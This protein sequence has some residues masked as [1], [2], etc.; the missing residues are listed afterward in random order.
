MLRGEERVVRR[1]RCLTT[2]V[3]L[4]WLDQP[5]LCEPTRLIFEIHEAWQL[6]T[7]MRG[8]QTAYHID[9]PV[10]GVN[11]MPVGAAALA[12]PFR[13][14]AIFSAAAREDEPLRV[15]THRELVVGSRDTRWRLIQGGR[16]PG[17]RLQ[18]FL[19]AREPGHER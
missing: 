9:E 19:T 8:P 10:D 12:G 4:P 14:L 3:A 15:S 1:F 6:L 11:W 13:D 17:A 2:L 16:S 7:S 18:R 5:Q